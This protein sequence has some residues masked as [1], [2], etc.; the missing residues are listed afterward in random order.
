MCLLAGLVAI[1]AAVT[2]GF[3]LGKHL[4]ECEDDDEDDTTYQYG[5]YREGEE[6]EAGGRSEQSKKEVPGEKE[7]AE[8]LAADTGRF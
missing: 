6:I 4:L 3:A 7:W 2:T 8:A 5:D 1:A